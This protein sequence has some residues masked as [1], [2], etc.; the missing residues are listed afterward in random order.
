MNYSE[1][2]TALAKPLPTKKE[3][4]AHALLGVISELGEL[5]DAWKKHTIYGQTLDRNNMIEELGDLRFY[6]QMFINEGVE[7]SVLSYRMDS[8]E[9]SL[10][11]TSKYAGDLA[12]LIIFDINV[13]NINVCFGRLISAWDLMCQIID[14]SPSMIIERNIKKLIKRYPD[15][16][17][18]EKH[19]IER[20]DKNEIF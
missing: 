15:K 6:L 9:Q 11:F 19:A 2:V 14:V 5:A 3:R 17:F 10:F 12:E 8:F 4:L 13:K 20:L 1:F 16:V 18:T 7:Y